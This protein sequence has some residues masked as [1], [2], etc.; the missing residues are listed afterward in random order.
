MLLFEQLF[1]RTLPAAVAPLAGCDRLILL[2]SMISGVL[3][4]IV[5]AN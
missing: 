2:A 1:D 3:I 4:S 5:S